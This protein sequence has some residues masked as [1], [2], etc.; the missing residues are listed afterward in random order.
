MTRGKRY[1]ALPKCMAHRVH[2][3]RHNFVVV[4]PPKPLAESED[5]DVWMAAG[6]A[7]QRS[8]SSRPAEGPLDC[9][10]D[11]EELGR[12]T[13]GLVRAPPRKNMLLLH[14]MCSFISFFP[15]HSICT[16]TAWWPL[17]G[18]DNA[19]PGWSRR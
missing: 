4:A 11:R 13:W 19:A 15:I 3:P 18:A 10:I 1:S 2:S 16:H 5:H 7:E 6:G 12:Y 8:S 9:P 14:A 17:P